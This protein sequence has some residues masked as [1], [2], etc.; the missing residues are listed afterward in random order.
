MWT[1]VY[2]GKLALQPRLHSVELNQI[3][4]TAGGHRLCVAVPA[5][6][7]WICAVGETVHLA[8]IREQQT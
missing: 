7:P 1:L 8:A 6:L 3:L 2:N 5:A 4:K